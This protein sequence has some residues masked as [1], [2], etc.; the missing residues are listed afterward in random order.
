MGPSLLSC[1]GVM[2]K[3]GISGRTFEIPRLISRGTMTLMTNLIVTG[4]ASTRGMRWIN[5]VLIVFS[6]AAVLGVVAAVMWL[7]PLIVSAD[8]PSP[9]PKGT[10]RMTEAE[11]LSAISSVRQHLLWA[12]GGL[13]AIVT[14]SF[15]WRRDQVARFGASLDRDANFTS[16]YT[17][18]ITQLG[19]TE[20]SIRL[21]GIYAL[22]R[23]AF[24]STR[25]HQT[26]LEVLAAY[27][28]ASSP[29]RQGESAPLLE[30][31]SAAVA[32]IGRLTR[33]RRGE[34]PINLQRTQLHETDL[35]GANLTGADLAGSD[36]RGTN[37]E[38]AYLAG[39]DLHGASLISAN[40]SRA[41]LSESNLQEADLS[42]AEMPHAVLKGAR[43][44]SAIARGIDL[45]RADLSGAMM[46][47][48]KMPDSRLPH[49]NLAGA[50]LRQVDFSRSSMKGANLTGVDL[51]ETDLT[52]FDT[53]SVN[54]DVAKH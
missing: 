4:S 54:L 12:A 40:L 25:D 35:R 31:V 10:A 27:V 49:A 51:S 47:G 20:R 50:D 30:D 46:W 22:E 15:T 44:P 28:R 41:D 43:M 26:I 13:I 52:T 6:V 33:L 16:R 34:R 45:T 32:V 3:A 2:K 42:A 36:L 48:V 18:A 11:R 29:R 5:A 24:D 19:S 17:E 8:L 7:P 37:L 1:V 9:T 38:G 21:G 14:L 39:A 23:I 53:S